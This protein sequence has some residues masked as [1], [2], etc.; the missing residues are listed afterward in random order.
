MNEF[1]RANLEE[2]TRFRPSEIIGTENYFH[3]EINQKK[4]MKL[5]IK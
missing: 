5:E 3:E 2:N 1:N 4:I